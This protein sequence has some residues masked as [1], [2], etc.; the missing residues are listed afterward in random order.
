MSISPLS[1]G[2][3]LDRTEE[4]ISNYERVEDET[5]AEE[6]DAAEKGL[7]IS[8]SKGLQRTVTAQDWTGPDDLEN[9]TNCPYGRKYIT[10]PYQECLALQSRSALQFTRL[11]IQR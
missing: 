10:L 1:R 8:Q 3:S 9:P 7:E 5:L 4:L 6:I 11:A 2:S